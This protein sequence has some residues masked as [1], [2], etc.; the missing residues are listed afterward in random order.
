M[1]V[2]AGR[3]APTPDFLDRLYVFNNAQFAF[4]FLFWTGLWAVK[5]AF[6]AFFYRLTYQLCWPRR[7]WW[8]ILV[9]AILSYIGCGKLNNVVLCFAFGTAS[10]L[11][12][13]SGL[14]SVCMFFWR[15]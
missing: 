3:Q 8:V 5:A 13:N 9:L 11:F 15:G 7:A 6:L 4:T 14:L 2:S 12:G 10:D 1:L